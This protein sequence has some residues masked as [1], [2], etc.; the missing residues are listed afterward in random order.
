MHDNDTPARPRLR[1]RPQDHLPPARLLTPE[2]VA[3]RLTV[4]PRMV[5]RLH[6]RRE[7]RAVKV[8]RFVRFAES[9]VERYVR[10]HSVGGAA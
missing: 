3:D 7:L 8:G 9:E 10:E 5:R 4:T 6:E 2:E 1:P